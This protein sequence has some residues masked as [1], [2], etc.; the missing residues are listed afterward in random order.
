MIIEFSQTEEPVVKFEHRYQ[1]DEIELDEDARLAG[2]LEVAG[3]ARRKHEQAHVKGKLKGQIAVACDRCLKAVEVPLETEFSV[4]YTTFENY[5]ETSEHA[6]L[7]KEDFA[8]S[9]YDGE[10]IDLAE[11]VREQ[12][13]LNLPV[14]QLC[15]ENC[16]GLCEKC[17]A[18]LNTE[19]CSCETKEIDPRWSALKD[20]QNKN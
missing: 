10:R 7:H 15:S 18:D 4:D 13:I 14:R 8:L 20:L 12:V 6:E 11:L 1:P 5:T 2:E 17:G 3:K 16:A 19:S 9:I